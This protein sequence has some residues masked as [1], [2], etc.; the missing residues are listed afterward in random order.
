[1]TQ[2]EHRNRKTKQAN[3]ERTSKE[4]TG[5][6]RH[7]SKEETGQCRH[8]SKD[9]TDDWRT[10]S[11]ARPGA[12]LG[13]FTFLFPI[14]QMR[15]NCWNSCEVSNI[16]EIVF[17]PASGASRPS[18]SAFL[19]SF[20]PDSPNGSKLLELVRA[21]RH[22]GNC[23]LSRERSEPAGILGSFTFFVPDSPND[24][25]LLELIRAIRHFGNCFLSGERSEPAGIFGFFTSLVPDSPNEAR[26]LELVP[27][28]RHFGNCFLST[29]VVFREF[30]AFCANESG[31]ISRVCVV[32]SSEPLGISR[33]FNLLC[34]RI[35]TNL[36][37]FSTLFEGAERASA[38]VNLGYFRLCL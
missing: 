36:A 13:F 14:R 27:A 18:F 24:G 34:S 15:R 31:Q 19:S 38:R 32:F 3:G 7:E 25:K 35:G 5:Q 6:R 29:G 10:E 20:V 22:F 2:I 17:F 28:I 1:M 37:D 33:E 26:L 21:I 16:L 30:S 9:K 23:F 12:I 8:E 11:K 4:E